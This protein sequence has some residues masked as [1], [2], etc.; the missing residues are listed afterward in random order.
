MI[1]DEELNNLGW[2]KEFNIVFKVSYYCVW[3][4]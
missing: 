2:Y 4:L 1:E 3:E